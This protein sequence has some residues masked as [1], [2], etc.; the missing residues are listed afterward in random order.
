MRTKLQQ[1]IDVVF[2]PDPPRDLHLEVAAPDDGFDQ[3]AVV[4]APARGIQVDHVYSLRSG[5]R[6]ADSHPNRII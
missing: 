6:E 4:A 1:C 2:A 5:S 3:V